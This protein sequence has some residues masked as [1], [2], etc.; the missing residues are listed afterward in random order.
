MAKRNQKYIQALLDMAPV[1]DQSEGLIWYERANQAAYRLMFQFE[2]NT[3]AQVVGV[4]AA[5]SPRNKWERNL[6]DAENLIEAFMAGGSRAAAEVKCCTF[7]A[8]KKKAIKI[9]ELPAGFGGSTE[10][11][12]IL[13]GPKLC[14]FC[15]CILGIDDV[16]IDGHAYSVW[17]GCRVA[18]KDV[19]KIGVKLRREIKADYLA[20][21][22]KNNLKGFEVQAITWLAHRRLHGV[23]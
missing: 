9:L 10:V 23:A 4:I 15:S 20:V 13:N 21:A 12:E 7:S 8:N 17:T 3:F 16:C 18:L 6:I 1:A 11:L 22:K 5:L 19:P 14:E 2:K